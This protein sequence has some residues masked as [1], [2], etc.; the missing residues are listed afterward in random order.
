MQG[1]LCLLLAFFFFLSGG[2]SESSIYKTSESRAGLLALGQPLLLRLFPVLRGT[3]VLVALC[4][5]LG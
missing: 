5:G 1:L 3:W 4:G 2:L